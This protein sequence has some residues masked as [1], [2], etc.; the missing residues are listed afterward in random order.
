M[1]TACPPHAQVSAVEQ[2]ASRLSA[3]ALLGLRGAMLHELN[4]VRELLLAHT[5]LGC[6]QLRDTLISLA[7]AQARG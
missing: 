1:L 6:C 2:R 4:A 5:T 3:A 7:V